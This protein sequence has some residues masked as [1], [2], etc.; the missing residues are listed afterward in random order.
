MTDTKRFQFSLLWMFIVTGLLAALIAGGIQ[1]LPEAARRNPA[2]VWVGPVFLG[3]AILGGVL[4]CVAIGRC[5]GVIYEAAAAFAAF[6]RRLFNRRSR[7]PK[8]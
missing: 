8:S 6:G 1:I 7:S 2:I 4:A 5:F 3:F